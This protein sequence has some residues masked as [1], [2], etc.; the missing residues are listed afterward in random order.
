[1]ASSGIAVVIALTVGFEVHAAG[2]VPQAS[3]RRWRAR[4]SGSAS[5]NSALFA[6]GDHADVD[7]RG[8]LVPRLV[9]AV[10]RHDARCST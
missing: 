5:P 9:H 4:R 1:M 2:T 7:R 3:A 10:R 8:Q 6:D